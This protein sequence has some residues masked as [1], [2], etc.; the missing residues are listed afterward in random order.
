M[1][2][3]VTLSVNSLE[4]DHQI[5][6]C[7]AVNGEIEHVLDDKTRVDCLTETHAI[8]FDFAKKWAEAIGQS[9]YYSAKTG[10]Q[11]GIVLIVL[12]PE[13]CRFADRIRTTIR[14]KDLAIKLW[15]TPISRRCN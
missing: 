7:Q 11:A 12:D 5:P 14:E 15:I 13:E 6:W 4:R 9:L 10:K 8:E 2:A 3:L 1:L